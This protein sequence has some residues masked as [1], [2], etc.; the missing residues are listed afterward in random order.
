MQRPVQQG[1]IPIPGDGVSA[2]AA[3]PSTVD[4]VVQIP[5]IGAA[6]EPTILTISEAVAGAGHGLTS[7]RSSYSI[8]VPYSRRSVWITPTSPQPASGTVFCTA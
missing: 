4:D 6:G 8:S 3:A 7:S 2:P 1:R 5:H